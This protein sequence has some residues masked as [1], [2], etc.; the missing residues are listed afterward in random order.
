MYTA[1]TTLL[2][3]SNADTANAEWDKKVSSFILGQECARGAA[4]LNTA[5]ERTRPLRDA[6][7]RLSSQGATQAYTQADKSHCIPK[8]VLESASAAAG[9]E[10]VEIGPNI[11]AAYRLDDGRR[12]EDQGD[13]I[14]WGLERLQAY[15][16]YVKVRII[17]AARC[18][19]L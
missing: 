14:R 10:F 13:T 6:A 9:S 7:A 2:T 3:H 4:L 16:F 12:V 5:D 8:S 1:P 11:G 19:I 18:T 15:I 17:T